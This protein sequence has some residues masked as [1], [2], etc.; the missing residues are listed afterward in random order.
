MESGNRRRRSAGADCRPRITS[1]GP[2]SVK[3]RPKRPIWL[4]S[5]RIELPTPQRSANFVSVAGVAGPARPTITG[6]PM[7]R[8]SS[9]P[10]HPRIGALSKQNCVTTSTR[11]FVGAP[12]PAS[13]EHLEGVRRLQIRMTFGMTGNAHR[14]DA[15]RLDQSAGADIEARLERTLRD[16]DIAGDQQN[17]RDIGLAAQPRQKIVERLAR[18]HFAR[19]DMRHR[20]VAGAAQRDGGLD[21]VAII[22]AGQE[23]DRDIGARD[24]N[25]PAILQLMPARGDLDGADASSASSRPEEA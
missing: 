6:R 24:E 4:R 19:G 14:C 25:D 5:D 22:V 11:M 2:V 3:S 12:S 8:A 9:S 18:G 20:V 10:I 15:V 17:A 7:P 23:G 21:V 13:F 1:S 16:R